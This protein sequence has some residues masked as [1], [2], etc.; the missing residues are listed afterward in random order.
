MT[1]AEVREKCKGALAKI[2]RDILMISIVLLASTAS[3]GLGFLAGMDVGQGSGVPVTQSPTAFSETPGQVLASK[4]GTKYYFP[5]CAGASAI[6][7]SNTIWFVSAEAAENAG[8]TR[9]KNCVAP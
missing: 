9:A 4:G 5:N 3:F 2:P 7:E 8:Y 1:I 6:S